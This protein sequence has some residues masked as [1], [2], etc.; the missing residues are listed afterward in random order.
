MPKDCRRGRDAEAPT[1]SHAQGG[2]VCI[3]AV[4]AASDTARQN[5]PEGSALPAKTDFETVSSRVCSRYRAGPLI[6][7]LV[8]QCVRFLASAFCEEARTCRDQWKENPGARKFCSRVC[9]DGAFLGLARPCTRRVA[10]RHGTP[11]ST[12]IEM[13]GRMNTCHESSPY[14]RVRRVATMR[15][16][17]EHGAPGHDA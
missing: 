8:S 14:D 17:K 2:A 5:F 15:R 10:R 1:L 12:E 7:A 9:G 4:R 13:S 11:K 6:R 16:Q 3:H